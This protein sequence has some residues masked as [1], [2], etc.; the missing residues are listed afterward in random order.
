M[1]I[2]FII[3][4]YNAANFIEKCINSIYLNSP[5]EIIAINDG[6]TDN[7]LQILKEIADKNKSLKIITKSNEG[8]LA[9]RRDGWRIAKGKY[10]C[11]V[12]ADDEIDCKVLSQI[13]L[14]CPTYDII[15][16]GGWYVKNG[17]KTEI[18]GSFKG[19][20]TNPINAI[21]KMMN[22]EMLPFMWGILFQR[23]LLNEECFQLDSRFKIG[24]DFLFNLLTMR[25]AS[26][27]YCSNYLLY[28]YNNNETSVMNTK[29]W[30]SN[31][32]REF[33]DRLTD[34]LLSISPQLLYYANR[35]RFRDYIE[36]LF[37]PEVRYDKS[38]YQTAVSLL[39]KYPKFIH[40]LPLKKRLFL[41]Q[42]NLF[43]LYLCLYKSYKKLKNKKQRIVL[44]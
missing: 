18:K 24:E 26:N 31:Y 44:Q 30:G 40:I 23:N 12:D 14:D 29:I 16:C 7:T 32:I 28:Y 41:R 3:P 27:I 2:S 15:R 6:S 33:N 11:F 38:L 35:H 4:C 43:R 13:L 21:T 17:E 22:K 9:A 42:E 1:T 5:Y 37:F 39:K 20:I 19:S 36:T 10:I 8:V 25:R 34:I